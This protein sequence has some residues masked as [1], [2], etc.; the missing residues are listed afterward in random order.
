MLNHVLDF[1]KVNPHPSLDEIVQA[2][3]AYADLHQPVSKLTEASLAQSFAGAVHDYLDH[4][5][6]DP[7]IPALRA[8]PAN[9]VGGT[10]TAGT[11]STPSVD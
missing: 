2:A 5:T 7:D 3:Y 1:L 9:P 11:G 6:A 8:R 10:A 4:N